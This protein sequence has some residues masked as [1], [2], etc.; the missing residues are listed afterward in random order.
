MHPKLPKEIE[1][2]RLAQNGLKLSGELSVKELPRLCE[3]LTDNKGNIS[4]DLAF[5]QDEIGTPYMAGKLTADVSMMCER[6]LSPM[7]VNLSVDCLLAVVISE[8]NIAALA[9]QYDP[10]LLE[11][12]APVSLNAVIE[13][14]LILALPLVPR[15]EEAC[16]PSDAWFSGDERDVEDEVAQEESP[17]AILSQLK[18]K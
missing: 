10:W 13:D 18:D 7:T 16:I 14:E 5:E 3:S 9:E 15:H 2:L 17:F 11:S 4:V 8:R 6:C 1:P 12:N